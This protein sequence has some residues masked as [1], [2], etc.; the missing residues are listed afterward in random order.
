ME[1]PVNTKGRSITVPLTS[2]LTGLDQS[3]LQIKTKVVSCHLV[4]SKP[5]TQEVNVT[6]IL[7]PLIFPEP[8]IDK[9]PYLLAFNDFPRINTLA[10]DTAANQIQGFEHDNIFS[11]KSN[12]CELP[13]WSYHKVLQLTCTQTYQKSFDQCEAACHCKTFLYV[14]ETIT[15]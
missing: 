14:T 11:G 2:C 1:P 12:I 13:D 10:T 9:M 5:V 3:V 6:V 15:K 4:N 7:P 8:P